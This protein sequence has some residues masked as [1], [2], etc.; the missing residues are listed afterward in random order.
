MNRVAEHRPLLSNFQF[1]STPLREQPC[2]E[3]SRSAVSAP[4]I[5]HR[6]RRGPLLAGIILALFVSLA[7]AA[8]FSTPPSPGLFV[9]GF[10][11]YQEKEY[12]VAVENL[13]RF[14]REQPASSLRD[15]T[16]YWLA[17]ASFH[18]GDRTGAARIMAR[19]LR[20][21]PEHPLT[22]SVEPE[23]LALA[24]GYTGETA[25][26]RKIV[27]RE[28][29]TLV[30]LAKRYGCSYAQLLRLNRIKNPDV[31]L[32]GD[33]LLIPVPP[34]QERALPPPMPEEKKQ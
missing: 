4:T 13:R 10:N 22:G 34:E 27:I 19:F 2:A 15:M 23:L 12:G 14:L 6:G 31:I 17:R 25:A 24:A 7:A 33:T 30:K 1:P 21:Y 28:G 29:D 32:I 18:A 11:A 8:A 5:C 9:A 26:S 3:R 20:E 16:L